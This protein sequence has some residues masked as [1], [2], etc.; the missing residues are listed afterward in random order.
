MFLKRLAA[1]IGW[2]QKIWCACTIIFYCQFL[3]FFYRQHS[4]QAPLHSPL[5][6]VP[7]LQRPANNYYF[8]YFV[9]LKVAVYPFLPPPYEFFFMGRPLRVLLTHA[10]RS[11]SMHRQTWTSL[12][13]G[14]RGGESGA[15]SPPSRARLINS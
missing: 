14:S 8:V 7:L 9:L 13:G 5:D 4:T 3:L 2:R 6:S 1:N 10:E 12:S 11:C 15:N